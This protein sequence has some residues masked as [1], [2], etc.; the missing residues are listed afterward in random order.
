MDDFENL[1]L[2]TPIGSTINSAVSYDTNEVLSN[3]IGV[4]KNGTLTITSNITMTNDAIIR[5]CENGKLIVDGG[6]IQNANLQ[7]I[8]G[9]EVVLQNGGTINMAN[10]CELNAPIGAVVT[11]KDGEIR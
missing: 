3:R 1:A 11:I 4:V 7:L 2:L 10:D 5:V 9:C 6:S 8:P